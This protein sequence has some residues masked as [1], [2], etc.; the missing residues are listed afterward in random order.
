MEITPNSIH[1][2]L[3]SFFPRAR[4]SVY[5]VTSKTFQGEVLIRAGAMSHIG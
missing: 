3:R 4:A 5:N 1:I 2:D